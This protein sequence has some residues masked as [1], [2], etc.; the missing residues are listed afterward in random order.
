[1]KTPQIGD[2]STKQQHSTLSTL[3][4]QKYA[5]TPYMLMRANAAKFHTAPSPGMKQ[6]Y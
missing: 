2:L 4:G 5:D 3:Y 1:M 6:N